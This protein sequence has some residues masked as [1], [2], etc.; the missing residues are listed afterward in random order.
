MNS[1]LAISV[2]AVQAFADQASAA[3]DNAFLLAAERRYRERAERL[4]S[5]ARSLSYASDPGGA[6]EQVLDLL[7]DVLPYD[8]SWL[9][10]LEDGDLVLRA[11]KGPVA[12][13]NLGQRTEPG[14]SAPLDGLIAANGPLVISNAR[15]CLQCGAKTL[16]PTTSIVDRCAA[17]CRWAGDGRIGCRQPHPGF[18]CDEDLYTVAAFADLAAVAGRKRAF[19]T[20][21]PALPEDLRELDRLKDE[22]VANVS[23]EAAR[24]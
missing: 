6:P 21:R 24:H 8:N 20:T 7:H 4:N 2:P 14:V 5:A 22:F 12:T 9:F 11:A 23:H 17:D 3:L 16:S 10:L 15:A 19:F 1:F 18:Y 13:V